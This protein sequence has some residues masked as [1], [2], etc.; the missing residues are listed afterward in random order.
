MI[1]VIHDGDHGG[2]DFINTLMLCA[3]TETFHLLGVTTVSGNTGADQ[4]ALNACKALALARRPDIPVMVGAMKPLRL[5][6]RLG[7][8]AFGGDG[9]GGVAWPAAEAPVPRAGAVEWMARQLDGAPAPVTLCV[10]GPA[11]NIALLLR[12]YPQAARK[13]ERIV[14]MGGGLNPAG[15]IKPYAEFNFYMDP[16]AANAVLCAGLPVVLHTLDTTHASIYTRARREKVLSLRPR[17]LA[18]KLDATMRITEALEEK[19]FGSEGSFFHDA[20][21]CAYLALPD[22]YE[23]KPVRAHVSCGDGAAEEGRLFVEDDP[24]GTVQ[25]VTSHKDPSYFFDYLLE[26]LRRVLDGHR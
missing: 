26:T 6:Y 23:T 11:T 15:N 9:I 24:S 7:D 16:D 22:N 5:P 19:L 10:T 12:D 21:T 4:A 14:M 13:I 20:Q 2:D 3:R 18:E 8:D 25:L 1:S 17:A